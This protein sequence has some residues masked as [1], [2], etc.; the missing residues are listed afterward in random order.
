MTELK[1]CPF[2]G[3][4]AELITQSDNEARY[5]TN[6]IWCSWCG[7]RT[8]DT[9]NPEDVIATWNA[10]CNTISTWLRHDNSNAW[11]CSN[12]HAVFELDKGKPED[13]YLNFCSVCGSKLELPE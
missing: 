12:C 1:P 6:F 11:E 5:S 7:C 4:K 10:R 8:S 9:Q 3:G 2:C 13:K